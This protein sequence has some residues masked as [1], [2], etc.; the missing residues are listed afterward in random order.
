MDTDQP[1]NTHRNHLFLSAV[2][3]LALIAAACGDD[4]DGDTASPTSSSTSTTTTTT[5]TSEPPESTTTTATTTTTTTTTSTTTT[6]EPPTTTAAPACPGDGAL[7][8][9]AENH[10]LA[11]GDV[12]GDGSLDTIHAYSIGD[13]TQLGAWWLQISFANGGVAT[14]QLMD[15]GTMIAGARPFDGFDINGDGRDE[16]F[17]R[18]GAGASAT[19]LGVFDVV[20]CTINRVTLGGQPTEL[21]AGASVN[22]FTG[23][24]CVDIDNNGAND[25]LVTYAGTRLGTSDEFEVTAAQYQLTN[26]DFVF[27]FADGIGGN[28]NDPG[29]AAMAQ[30]G[31]PGIVL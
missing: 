31:C 28:V 12:N 24:E 5:T 17:A 23:F 22:N 11:A 18:V 8:A 14:H 3:T 9:Q 7:P 4:G 19:I 1:M 26:G 25:F 16:F 21:A 6:T 15:S 13:P 30:A 20:N 27:M 29:F 10:Q 2:L